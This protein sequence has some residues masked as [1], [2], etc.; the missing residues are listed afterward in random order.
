MTDQTQ[1]SFQQKTEGVFSAITMGFGAFWNFLTRPHPSV[2]EVGNRRQ[3][4][5]LSALSLILVGSFTWA[6][7]SN[8]RTV[9]SFLLF[10]GITLAAYIASRTRLYR[11]GAYFFSFCF[12]SIAYINI[13]NGS[14][15]SIDTSIT[16]IVPISLILASAILSQRGFLVLAIA[17][18]A[19]TASVRSYADP[20]FLADT[21]FSFGRTIGI[22]F[23]TAIILYG[24]TVFRASV[25]R[26]RLKEVQVINRELESLSIGLEQRIAERIKALQISAEVSHRLTGILDQKELVIEVVEQVRNAFNYYHAHIYLLDE[27]GHELIMA[28]GTGEAGKAMLAHGHKISKGKGLVGRAAETNTT[29]LVAD[30]TAS[31][32]WL[33]NPLLPETK[34]EVAVPIALGGRVQGVLD[35]QHNVI[36]GLTQE[37]ADLLQS[38][39]NQVAVAL[40]NARSYTEAQVRAEREALMASMG[41]KIQNTSTV[42]STLQVVARELGRALGVRDT[43]VILK[44][45]NL[46]KGK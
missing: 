11:I 22:T 10:L 3:A 30:T 5:L 46:R 12:T 6:I 36:N 9:G 2:T 34:S 39:A 16:S 43:R 20:K 31:P 37:D 24:I 27:S 7:L 17:T 45:G 29:V 28:G 1:K 38:I 26:A 14:A 41:Q 42:E 19:A 23:S 21:T 40:Q 4:Q 32:D 18:V 33:P 44:A 13:S 35:V 15:N 8:P 25:E